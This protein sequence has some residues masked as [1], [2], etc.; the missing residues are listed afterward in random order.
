[1]KKFITLFVILFSAIALTSCFGEL[2][3]LEWEVLPKSVYYVG[4]MTEQK[5]KESV[6]IKINRGDPL[7]LAAALSSNPTDLTFTGFDLGSTGSKMITIKYKSVSIYWAYQVIEGDIPSDEVTPEY[8]WYDGKSSP[9][10]L[11]SIE[12]LYGFANIVNGKRPGKS[13]HSFAGETVKLGANIDLTGKVWEPIGAA[14]RKIN[15]GVDFTENFYNTAKF[16]PSSLWVSDLE[17]P[18]IAKAE[19]VTENLLYF[20]VTKASGKNK[21]L[22]LKLSYSFKELGVP[23]YN[24]ILLKSIKHD[25]LDPYKVGGDGEDKDNINPEK[26][27]QHALE[28][29]NQ[30]LTKE[31]N[32]ISGKIFIG[33]YLYAQ[34]VTY[35]QEGYENAYETGG[36]KYQ[37]FTSKDVEE[38]NFFSGTFDGQGHKIIGLSDV[39]YTPTVELTYAN[40]GT[41]VTGYTFGLFG[42]VN[43]DVTVKNLR[44]EDVQVVGAYYDTTGEN[45]KLV[46]AEI[47]SVGAAIGFAFGNGNLTL[48][49]VKVL[50]GSIVG[51][52]AVGGIVGRF[53]NN[54]NTLIQNCENYANISLTGRDAK[55]TG[56]IAG[57]GTRSGLND[58]EGKTPHTVIFKNNTNYGN[59]TGAANMAGAMVRYIGSPTNKI[60]VQFENCRNFGNITGSSVSSHGLVGLKA[61]DYT[62]VDPVNYGTIV[63]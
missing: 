32:M 10:T 38:G 42:V 1:M 37:F 16:T 51:N 7:T 4:E 33:K 58:V 41:I 25:E 63:N 59:V 11:S 50:S 57:Y 48:D 24:E 44:F 39:G 17:T 18:A 21:D 23:K 29:L 49:N 2:E 52:Q 15:T 62:F 35:G 31:D 13:A 5:F 34:E 56:G 3:S 43:G 27:K 60:Y 47:D 9:Y 46:L 30:E 55:H 40:S 26:L 8:D 45:P 22:V 28:L 54:G 14:P 20:D 53:Y 12:D 6:S 36:K 19:P 61:T